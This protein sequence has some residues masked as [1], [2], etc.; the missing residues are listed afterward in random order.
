MRITTWPREDTEA[1]EFLALVDRIR[2]E[3]ET[4]VRGGHKHDDVINA[5]TLDVVSRVDPQLTITAISTY[6]EFFDFQQR[7][8]H[9]LASH[10]DIRRLKGKYQ[11]AYRRAAQAL[12]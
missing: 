4:I 10:R 6:R 9:L 5:P 3:V 12:T 1:I 7:N 8:P 11:Q 2:R